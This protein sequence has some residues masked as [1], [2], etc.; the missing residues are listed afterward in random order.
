M[1][2]KMGAKVTEALD[3]LKMI[4][5]QYRTPLSDLY[6]DETVRIQI[7]EA[8]EFVLANKYGPDT[9]KGSSNWWDWE[10]G[11]PRSM[12]D[13]AFLMAEE[14]PAA[15]K[16]QIVK[17]IDRF[18]PQ[19]GLPL[20]QQLK[21]ETGANLIDKVSIVIKR[22]AFEGNSER[23]EHA[24]SCM[25]LLFTYVTSGDGFYKDGSFIQHTSIPYNGSYGFVLLDELTNCLIMLNFTE[26][27]V[28]PEDVALYETFLKR[29]LHSVPFLRRQ[30]ARLSPRPC[31]IPNGAARRYDGHEDD[32]N[33]SAVC[34]NR[35]YRIGGRASF[36]D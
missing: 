17:T 2:R 28:S 27:A 7:L 34:G 10:I 22:A 36:A 26:H 35:G 12:M 9:K 33:H 19:G 6:Q 16:Q 18:V 21:K 30:R 20:E 5:T 31:G 8:M 1:T 4:A 15:M 25:A 11:S 3:R 32:G 24:Q 13:V 23:L 14:L 29:F